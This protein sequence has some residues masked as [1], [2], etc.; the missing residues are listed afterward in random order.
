M[1]TTRIIK[2]NVQLIPSE[3]VQI[4]IA[5]FNLEILTFSILIFTISDQKVFVLWKVLI[6]N[7]R[8]D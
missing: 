1:H 8:I 2:L 5:H 3:P 4:Y 6:F 7:F